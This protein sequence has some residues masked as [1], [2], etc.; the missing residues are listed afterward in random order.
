M[1]KGSIQLEDIALVNIYVP[2]IGAFKY[3]KQILTELKGK[4]DSNKIIGDFTFPL[5][6][7][8]RLSRQKI[9]KATLALKN[10]L[11]QMNLIDIYRTYHP[12][13]ADYLF[14]S[15][16]HGIFSR[17]EHMIGHRTSLNKF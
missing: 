7:M 6:S 10:T 3:T 16:A 1:I 15:S 8:D 14:F 4:I 2:N 11:D 12:K 13:I 5:T 9:N 17:I